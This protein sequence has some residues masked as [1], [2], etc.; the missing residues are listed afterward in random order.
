MASEESLAGVG[1]PD[2]PS[3]DADEYSGSHAGAKHARPAFSFR[4]D[5]ESVRPSELSKRLGCEEELWSRAIVKEA[6]DNSL[7]AVEEA[8][9]V[10]PEIDI[11]IAEGWI[12]VADDGPGMPAELVAR[13]CDRDLRTSSREA[14]PTP[15]RGRQGNA[16]QVL[17][18][19]AF[20]LGWSGSSTRSRA[21]ASSTGSCS[22]STGS[23]SRSRWSGRRSR[24][25]PAAAPSSESD[26]RS[27]RSRLA[28]SPGLHNLIVDFA[29]LNPHCGFHLRDWTGYV[30]DGEPLIGDAL[31]ESSADGIEKW[32]SARR[33]RR[34]GTASSGSVTGFSSS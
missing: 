12:E 8:G 18:C 31:I 15:E 26:S 25:S 2:Q 19:L 4:R 10:R 14:W 5:L 28:S 32:D 9:T 13:L 20:G 27:M 30:D 29:A 22:P 3:E 33:S 11:R 23:R 16:L 17:M 6:L 24:S 1:R 34:T 21:R 7:D